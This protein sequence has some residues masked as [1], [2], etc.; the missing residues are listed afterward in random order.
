M[1]LETDRDIQTFF[2]NINISNIIASNPAVQR[3]IEKY[4]MP[5]IQEFIDMCD[6]IARHSIE[7][8]VLLA[9]TVTTYSFKRDL[10][11]LLGEISYTCH[12][13]TVNLS[14]LNETVY[15]KL[16]TLTEKYMTSNVGL[17]F[18]HDND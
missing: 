5:E 8:Y 12:D 14:A 17:V 16:N 3:T 9:K 13:K 15:K 11:R 1:N 10:S 18:D 4:N 7:E 2:K 6:E